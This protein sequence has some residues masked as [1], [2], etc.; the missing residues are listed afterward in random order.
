MESMID[1]GE[2]VEDAKGW[3]SPPEEHLPENYREILA[4]GFIAISGKTIHASN[5]ATSRAPAMMPGPCDCDVADLTTKD[6][7]TEQGEK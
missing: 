6:D 1:R 3:F 7:L 5:C 4:V 2:L